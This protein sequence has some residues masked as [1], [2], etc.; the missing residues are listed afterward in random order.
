MKKLINV[1]LEQAQ[2]VEITSEVDL[3]Y[4]MDDN[5]TDDELLAYMKTRDIEIKLSDLIIEDLKNVRNKLEH[6][7]S[8]STPVMDGIK[9]IE[10]LIY[11]IV[12]WPEFRPTLIDMHY[13]NQIDLKSLNQEIQR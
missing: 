8:T 1:T 9:R 2:P 13:R 4:L 12:K 11:E 10:A 7:S 6:P 3:C 5:L